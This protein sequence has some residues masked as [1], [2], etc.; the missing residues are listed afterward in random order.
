MTAKMLSEF[1]VLGLN[2]DSIADELV[3]YVNRNPRPKWIKFSWKVLNPLGERCYGPFANQETISSD[4]A[5]VIA[6]SPTIN[7][8]QIGKTVGTYTVI[9]H[10]ENDLGHQSI[11]RRTFDMPY[12]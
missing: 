11:L 5:E 6:L 3:V 7:V 10:L 9:Y 4:D 1:G 2:K 8:S 12:E